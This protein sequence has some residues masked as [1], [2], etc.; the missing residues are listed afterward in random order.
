MKPSPTETEKRVLI[1]DVARDIAT[2]AHNGQFRRDGV[3]PYIRHPEAV[4]SRLSGESAYV[5]AAAWLHDV[6]EDTHFDAEVL[7]AHGI[8][9]PVIT[10]VEILTKR[11]GVKYE[12]YL[13]G[14][15]ICEIARKVKIADMLCNLADSPTEKQTLKYAKGLSFLLA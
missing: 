1:I 14:V 5:Q 12:D 11:D 4:A 9:Q 7:Y 6:I 13:D 3:T 15:K 2:A 10:A 8:P